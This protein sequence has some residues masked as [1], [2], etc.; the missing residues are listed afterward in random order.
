M[1]STLHRFYRVSSLRECG[2]TIPLLALCA[3]ALLLSSASHASDPL[4]RDGNASL[5]GTFVEAGNT[6]GSALSVGWTGLNIRFPHEIQWTSSKVQVRN[7]GQR[8]CVAKGR[9]A[10]G[11]V[12]LIIVEIDGYFAATFTDGAGVR[13]NARDTVGQ[14]V[15]FKQVAA[16]ALDFPRA[17][18]T[19]SPELKARWNAAQESQQNNQGGIAGNCTDSETVDVLVVYTPCALFQSGS[20]GQLLADLFLGETITNTALTNSAIDTPETPRQIRIVAVH[21]TPIYPVICGVGQACQPDPAEPICGSDVPFAVDLAAVSDINTPLGG[22]VGQ[23]RDY[24]SAD[25]VIMVRVGAGLASYGKQINEGCISNEGFMV[26]GEGSLG[27][28][29]TAMTFGLGFLFGCCQA[30]GDNGSCWEGAIFPYSSGHRFVGDNQIQYRTI[31]TL[32]PGNPITYF[33]N[34]D[35]PFEGQPTGTSEFDSGQAGYWS[36]NAR[37]IRNTFDDVRCYRCDLEPEVDPPVGAVVC[38]G[39]NSKGQVTVPSNLTDCKRV[40][41]GYL[42]TVAIQV[43]GVVRAWGA[44]SPTSAPGSTNYGQSKV[45]VVTPEPPY[46]DGELLGTCREIAAG[47]YHTV[48]IRQRDVDDDLDGTVVCWGAGVIGTASPNFGQSIVPLDLDTCKK[49]SAGHYHTLALQRNGFVRSWGAGFGSDVWPHLGQSAVPF[50]LGQ[51]IDI[52][53]GGYHSVAIKLGS[54]SE[55]VY[56]GPVVAWGAGQT[57]SG[58]YSEYGQSIVPVTLGDCTRVAAGVFHT[59]ALKRDGTVRAFG[60]GITN[61]GIFPNYGQSELQAGLVGVTAIA[62]GGAYIGSSGSHTLALRAEETIR[63]WG[64]NGSSQTDVPLSTS[65]WVSI[66]A[67]G[68]HSVAIQNASGFSSCLGDFNKDGLRDGIDLTTLLSGWGSETGDCTGDGTTDGSDLTLLLSGWGT[69][70]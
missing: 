15:I 44:G 53:A 58:W 36:D 52:A 3:S 14:P 24:H 31:M 49:V 46:G 9:D 51:C 7:S 64:A 68:L 34:P 70:Q 37:T 29:S 26:I 4:K 66:A 16:D 33:S 10:S 6:S 35:V 50:T 55:G 59:V 47:L 62:A 32:F 21:P 23:M 57:N 48:A 38:W 28:G 20:L 25:L 8:S 54:V 22:A 56:A 2:R 27:I 1:K 19:P 43:D 30:P 40:A 13:W 39:S 18:T 11:S 65:G 63:A 42:H 61:T 17:A 69:C 67:G 5:N 41:A 60:A 45:P 12:E